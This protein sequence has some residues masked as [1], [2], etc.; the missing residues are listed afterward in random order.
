MVFQ[1]GSPPTIRYGLF[2][3]FQFTP[4][5]THIWEAWYFNLC[6]HQLSDIGC[7]SYLSSPQVLPISDRHGIKPGSPPTIKY[8][9][10]EPV[11]CTPRLTRICHTWCLN[12]GGLQ[13]LPRQSAWFHLSVFLSS[14]LELF[15]CC[16]AGWQPRHNLPLHG[17]VTGHI[18][19]TT[20][21][22]M[23]GVTA[24]G[25]TFRYM[26]GLQSRAQSAF[27]WSSHSPGHSHPLHDRFTVQVKT[28]L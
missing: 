5:L 21:L 18:Q 7:L 11:K 16:T 8:G 10:L 1:P 22:Y 25:T 19:G 24:Q 27:T 4:G 14:F 9:L 26:I 2:E 3:L 23:A 15:L 13:S 12:V 6:L 20:S 28:S 17:Q